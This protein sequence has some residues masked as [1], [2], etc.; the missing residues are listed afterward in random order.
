[1]RTDTALLL[2]SSRCWCCDACFLFSCWKETLL[3]LSALLS[4]S[5]SDSLSLLICRAIFDQVPVQSLPQSARKIALDIILKIT[6]TYPNELIELG[7]YTLAGIIRCMDGEKDPR[8]LLVTFRLARFLLTGAD[9]TAA[10]LTA[11]NTQS[12]AT[13][14][15][16]F[17][18]EL[19]Q[20]YMEELFEITS[21]YFPIT[22]HPPK[23]DPIG[24]TGGD[25][26][27][28]LRQVFA[29]H[30]G[31][32]EFV[33]PML[34]EKIDSS[35][36]ECKLDVLDTMRYCIDTSAYHIPQ[37]DPFIDSIVKALKKEM[38]QGSTDDDGVIMSASRTFS[39][40]VR[41]FCPD[42]VGG[43]SIGHSDL[44]PSWSL[45]MGP[46]IEEIAQ[47]LKMPDSKMAR[48]YAT[49]MQLVCA[50]T[51]NAF[52]R[53]MNALFRSSIEAKFYSPHVQPTQRVALLDLLNLLIAA[54]NQSYSIV[55]SPHPLQPFVESMV[56]ILTSVLVDGSAEQRARA[57]EGIASIAALPPFNTIEETPN[58]TSM[59]VDSG[60]SSSSGT[61]RA[62]VS[63]RLLPLDQVRALIQ[64]LT[65]RLITDED[66]TVRQRCLLGLVKLSHDTLYCP[67]VLKFTLPALFNART[68]SLLPLDPSAAASAAALDASDLSRL[69]AGPRLASLE[70]VL[71][72]ASSL[73]RSPTLLAAT[74]P[75]IIQ[76]VQA[77]FIQAIQ[78]NTQSIG[79]I[80]MVL[81]CLGDILASHAATAAG[82]S[83]L[84]CC[85]VSLPNA[86]VGLLVHGSLLIT[87]VNPE[88][89]LD[90]KVIGMAVNV[91]Q[92]LVRVAEHAAQQRMLQQMIDLFIDGNVNA[93][94]QN[95]LTTPEDIPFT[96]LLIPT[97]TLSAPIP[98]SQLQLVPLFTCVVG[99][100]R[101]GVEFT[102][103]PEVI[104]RLGWFIDTQGARD[105]EIHRAA[106]QCLA[107]I[108][109]K[110]PNDDTLL[111]EFIDQH[112]SQRLF[113]QLHD[114]NTDM[115]KRLLA[116]TVLAWVTATRII[117]IDSVRLIL[118]ALSLTHLL[119]CLSFLSF[120][121][122]ESAGDAKSLSRSRIHREDDSSTHTIHDGANTSGMVWT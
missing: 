100:L 95:A 80:H 84:D 122:H 101:S 19:L 105:A 27:L 46:L 13:K 49:I 33:L 53:C 42:S 23:N 55:L 6:Q 32:A 54:A 35:V 30:S 5:L 78:G 59:G 103:L 83:C 96:P 109:N 75:H 11:G 52:T 97:D 43:F 87:K 115:N 37:W 73:C 45:F 1:M 22:F 8:N 28:S 68:T 89:A 17:D 15:T 92:S 48:S 18:P 63:R 90:A 81:A 60:S 117:L 21:C 24:I 39:S 119:G 25:L 88:F 4:R 114:Q 118:Y 3:G 94:R 72:A 120:S 70:D 10:A 29:S 82:R 41:L 16:T 98:K 93:F 106:I 111:N 74:L 67:A 69:S 50:T 47:E 51:V 57:V 12:G 56:G 61:P 64:L 44:A 91:L 38:F 102:R 34:I 7:E 65:D 112:L 26:Q 110:L 71:D 107:A 40:L 76:M 86:L 62:P 36:I 108:I 85:L 116:A 104:R 58:G 2:F 9:G 77:H 99:S 20:Q 14:R 31:L 66:E 113:T 121:V 79:A